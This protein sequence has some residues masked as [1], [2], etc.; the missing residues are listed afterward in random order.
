MALEISRILFPTDFSETSGK[1][2]TYALEIARRSKA[3]ITMVHTIEEPYNFAPLLEE[4]KQQVS[5]RVETLFNEQL[6]EIAEDEQYKDIEIDTRILHG[7]VAFAVLD[8]ANETKA[9]LIVMGTTGASGLTKLLF[10]TKTIEIILASRIPVLAIPAKSKFT[11]LKQITFLTDYNEGDLYEL[12]K[13]ADFAELFKSDISVV[14][15]E[16]DHNFKNEILFRGFKDIASKQVA[17]QSMQ[18]ELV[19]EFSFFTGVAAFLE[20]NPTDMLTMVR[21]RKP[22]FSKMLNKDHSKEL[23]FYSQVPLLVLVNNETPA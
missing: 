19:T 7:R 4:Y 23:G 22:F 6:A 2:L 21:Y 16:T 15:I 1:A 12:K 9:D 10:G 20:S 11:G 13:T 17:H 18:F 3:T 5:R 8:E 14:H